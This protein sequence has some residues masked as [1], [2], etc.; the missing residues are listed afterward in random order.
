[1]RIVF[2]SKLTF[3]ICKPRKCR[4]NTKI[5]VKSL[6]NVAEIVKLLQNTSGTNDKMEILKANKDNKLL[7][8]LLHYTYNPF[9]MYG[10]TPNVFDEVKYDG[11]FGINPLIMINLCRKLSESNINN[12]LRREVIE[13]SLLM[14]SSE[15][16]ELFKGILCKDLKL[17]MNAKTLNKVWKGLIPTFD[18]QLAESLGKLP[19]NFLNGKNFTIT[20]K[21]DGFRCLYLPNKNKFY[22]RKGQEYEGVSHLTVSCKYFINKLQQVTGIADDFV[23]DGE[24]I[25]KPVDGLDSGALYKL[26]SSIARKKGEQKDKEKL[27]FNVFDFIPLSEYNKAK[28]TMTYAERR[29]VLDEVDKLIDKTSDTFPVPALYIGKDTSVI[30][31]LLK[32]IEEDGGEGLMININSS[33]YEFKRHKGVL[34]VKSFYTADVWVESVYEGEKGKEFEGTLGGVTVVFLYG[35]EFMR[36]NVGSGFT[37]EERDAFW[38]DP[39]LIRGR[40]I[41]VD[42]FELSNNKKDKTKKSLRFA[43]YKHRI[44]DDKT[45]DDITDVKTN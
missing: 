32:E 7:K 23:L 35:G 25:H 45:F 19:D 11:G 42:Y 20:P 8:L 36:T 39:T 2:Y 22:T 4:N 40:V 12:D 18:V 34:K 30:Q 26:T 27:Q 24:L 17:G 3:K 37:K 29:R 1:M 6:K 13:L 9:M 31:P 15:E 14:G 33:K 28:T 38:N 44:R 43:T 16:F 5:E 21:L 10:I 41:E